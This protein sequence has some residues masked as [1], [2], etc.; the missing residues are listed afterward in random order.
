VDMVG[1]RDI[2]SHVKFSVSVRAHPLAWLVHRQ[3]ENSALILD[4]EFQNFVERDISVSEEC[5]KLKAMADSLGHL[6][7]HALDRTL[8]P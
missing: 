5:R 7:K 2:G 6:G 1:V 4:A 8:C 3:Q